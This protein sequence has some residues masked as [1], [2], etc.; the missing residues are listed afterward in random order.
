MKTVPVSKL[1]SF[2]MVSGDEKRITKVIHNG[3]VKEWVGI[4]WVEV[5]TP[6]ERDRKTIPQAVYDDGNPA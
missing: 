4:G 5:R 6:T 1:S 2:A 3:K